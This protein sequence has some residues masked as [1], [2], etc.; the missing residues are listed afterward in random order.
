MSK[1]LAAAINKAAGILEDK[2]AELKEIAE[3]RKEAQKKAD[4]IRELAEQAQAEAARAARALANWR[5]PVNEEETIGNVG[6]NVMY[7]SA[8]E[9]SSDAIPVS[10]S[11]ASRVVANTATPQVVGSVLG[12][13]RRLMRRIT[14]SRLE[15]QAILLERD[16]I[17]A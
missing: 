14:S 1:K 13:V 16:L 10:G 11:S 12:A 15:Q 17:K 8:G 9:S 7:Y 6:G 3:T 2:Q 4:D 5:A